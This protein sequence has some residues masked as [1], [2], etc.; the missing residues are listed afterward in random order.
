MD[1]FED[2]TVIVTGAGTG[3]GRAIARAFVEKGACV[4][5]IGR[6][7]EKLEEAVT[8]LPEERFLRAGCDVSDRAAVNALA[9]QVEK[10]FGKVHILVNNAG[11]NTNPRSV[12]E[13]DPEDWDRTV[14]INL[15]GAFNMVRAV[16]P[17]MR[18]R[19]DG[20]IVNV[21]STAG[22]R[23]SELAGAAYSAAKHGMVALTHSINEE[24]RDYGIRSCAI[25]PGEVATPILEL[26]PEPVEP[27]RLER[28]LQP[29]DIAA[30]VLFVAGLPPRA[31]VPELIIKPVYQIFQ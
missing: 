10:R 13:V 22:L 28:M 19:K 20:V 14:A 7:L 6:R 8:G 4:A 18:A 5:F 29:E 31:C 15:T 3:M 26:R 16:L 24:E 9:E 21:S 27:E 25:C 23:A 1:R 11:I 30:T 2:K 12:S 17:G